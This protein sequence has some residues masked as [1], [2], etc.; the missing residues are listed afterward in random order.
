MIEC[1]ARAARWDMAA[2]AVVLSLDALGEMPEDICARLEAAIE[3]RGAW[4]ALSAALDTALAAAPKL[5]SGLVAR[6]QALMA[7]WHR[8]RLADLDGAE[9]L[10]LRSVETDAGD[11]EVWRALA[12]LQRRHPGPA[13][14]RSLVHL[15]GLAEDPADVLH[16]AAGIALGAL[17]GGYA[18]AVLE[19]YFD[20]IRDRWERGLI[21]PPDEKFVSVAEYLAGLYESGGDHER[22]V[23]LLR[24][25]LRLPVSAPAALA[26]RRRAAL[27]ILQ[28]GGGLDAAVELLRGVTDQDPADI[29]IVRRLSA[30]YDGS[31]QLQEQRTLW[32]RALA[33]APTNEARLESRLE[34]AN[35]LSLLGSADDA[36]ET[37]RA[38]LTDVPGHAATLAALT[39]ILERQGRSDD[40]AALLVQQARL[41]DH[42][43]ERERGGDLW[44]QAADVFETM[45]GDTERA[46]ESH[47]QA[48]AIR[49]TVRS[50]EALARVNT[51][52]GEHTLAAKRLEQLRAMCEPAQALEVT[53]RLA[54]AYAATGDHARGIER[55]RE[56]WA[57]EPHRTDAKALLVELYRASQSWD[58]LY[59]ALAETASHEMAPDVRRPLLR[60]AAEIAIERLDAPRRAV[61]LLAY[62]VELDPSDDATRVAWAAALRLSGD[63]SSSRACL[64]E[65]LTKYGRRRP[66]EKAAVHFLSLLT[67]RGTRATWPKRWNNS[68]SRSGSTL[69]MPQH[70]ECSA[71]SR[72]R[73]VNSSA[74]NTRFACCCSSPVATTQ[75]GTTGLRRN[76]VGPS[77]VLY[78]LHVIAERLH[79]ERR[80]R[81]SLESAFE[82]AR[83]SASESRRLE[84]ALRNAGASR[85]L[86]RAL[87]S[88]LVLTTDPTAAVGILREL[89][90]IHRETEGDDQAALELLLQAVAYAPLDRALHD[91]TRSLA[92]ATG[93]PETYVQGMRD[94]AERSAH[95]GASSVAHALYLLLGE[96]CE[97]LTDD[98][99]LVA[100]AYEAARKHVPLKLAHF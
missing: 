13:L 32:E 77:E 48:V 99:A 92:A 98:P 42:T 19:R 9:S 76:S 33:A 86:V 72:A 91:E 60:E 66:P 69:V 46:L 45:L 59:E 6:M 34:L 21:A 51:A 73:P 43:V 35:A 22:A 7:R 85:L 1:A 53:M 15:S 23:R 38:S 100:S 94:L 17:D 78:Q 16:E 5:S 54:R 80:S 26:L 55:L 8:D 63:L 14:V 27:T 82:A 84:R 44:A 50:L 20:A 68:I 41:L 67:S 40:L 62:A 47:R 24:E 18:R 30:Y 87:K 4:Q 25:A 65:M 2:Q 10:L 96:A 71:R 79:Q 83:H 49:P 74:P 89:A 95:A 81:E 64:L 39:P 93:R 58:L 57:A 29:E 61:P 97:T 11:P 3:A 70:S 88:R 31:G 90:A 52:M 28:H 36:V 75:S 12:E 37:L 56:A